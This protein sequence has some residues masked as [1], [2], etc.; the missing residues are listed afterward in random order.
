VIPIPRIP[1][2]INIT[3]LLFAG[4]FICSIEATEVILVLEK[5]SLQ[6]ENTVKGI[7]SAKADKIQTTYS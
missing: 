6:K 4:H 3:S 7:K 2:V 5:Y 1:R